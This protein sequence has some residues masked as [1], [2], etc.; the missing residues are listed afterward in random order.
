MECH[1]STPLLADHLINGEQPPSAHKK[2]YGAITLLNT[3]IPRPG[4]VTNT[5][6]QDVEITFA[7][8]QDNVQQMGDIT[9]HI[10]LPHMI[11]TNARLSQLEQATGGRSLAQRLSALETRNNRWRECI[12]YI[13]IL[14]YIAGVVSVFTWAKKQE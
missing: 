14:V 4:Q 8:M 10:T 5:D 11:A 12:S 7:Q 13:V 1:A 3:I 9:A 2:P 6:Q